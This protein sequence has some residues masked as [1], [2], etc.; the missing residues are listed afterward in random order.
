M[1][2]ALCAG[3]AGAVAITLASP[4]ALT[5]SSVCYGTPKRGARHDEHYHV[6]FELP[7]RRFG[8]SK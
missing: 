2:K 3:F 1:K 6:D 4:M 7:C 5:A 8:R